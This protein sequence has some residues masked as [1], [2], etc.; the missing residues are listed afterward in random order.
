MLGPASL[1][2]KHTAGQTIAPIRLVS[3]GQTETLTAKRVKART[4]PAAMTAHFEAPREMQLHCA[5]TQRRRALTIHR[6]VTVET[7]VFRAP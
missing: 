3:S 6:Q 1:S 5:N 4:R 7:E 2:I